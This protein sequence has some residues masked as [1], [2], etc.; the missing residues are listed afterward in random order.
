V[1]TVKELAA[2]NLRPG[3]GSPVTEES[4]QTADDRR[5]E[6]ALL[7]LELKNPA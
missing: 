6:I 1:K 3:L 2:G 7:L 5:V 4:I